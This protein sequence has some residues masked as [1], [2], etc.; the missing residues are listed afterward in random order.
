MDISTI[1]LIIGSFILG[2]VFVLLLKKDKQGQ[3]EGKSNSNLSKIE[4]EKQALAKKLSDAIEE[5]DKKTTDIKSKYEKLLAEAK[6][7]CEKLDS[8]LKIVESLTTVKKARK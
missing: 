4:E 3:I 2:A 7:Q 6:A 5:S 1:L 8:E